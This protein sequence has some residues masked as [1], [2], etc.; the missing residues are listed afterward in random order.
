MH[1]ELQWLLCRCCTRGAAP[2]WGS[3]SCTTW[4][5]PTWCSAWRRRASQP[6]SSCCPRSRARSPSSWVRPRLPPLPHHVPVLSSGVAFYSCSSMVAAYLTCASVFADGAGSTNGHIV[7]A[8]RAHTPASS[9]H[10]GPAQ[11]RYGDYFL[12]VLASPQLAEPEGLT[13]L[14]RQVYPAPGTR[15]VRICGPSLDSIPSCSRNQMIV[16]PWRRLRAGL[17]RQDL[18][19]TVHH[20]ADRAQKGLCKS[21]RLPA[22][23]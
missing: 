2:A 16:K 23:T 17:Y 6:R 4:R 8:S 14:L 22:V 12:T 18:C 19:M 11:R 7:S 20:T 3:T 13:K 10:L 5:P 9:R 1:A 21:L 15:Q